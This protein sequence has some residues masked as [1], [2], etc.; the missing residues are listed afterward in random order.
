MNKTIKGLV[1]ATLCAVTINAVTPTIQAVAM[2]N[3]SVKNEEA[4]KENANLQKVVNLSEKTIINEDKILLDDTVNIVKNLIGDKKIRTNLS[5]EHY[6][7]ENSSVATVNDVDNMKSLTIPIADEN[8]SI[9]S[10]LTILLDNNNSIISYTELNVERSDSNTFEM[11]IFENGEEFY[12]EITDINFVENNEAKVAIEE[13]SEMGNSKTRGLD[14]PCFV[15]V[16]GASAGVAGLI[17][18][19]CGSPCALLPPVCVACLG[20]IVVV[21]GAGI[22][23]AVKACWN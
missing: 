1:M 13:L 7:F 11:I 3:S 4:L 6:N 2:T 23:G 22:W 18:K 21:G 16:S 20:G 15:A 10:N 9:L 5:L 8:L 14:V 17:L 19:L 12:R